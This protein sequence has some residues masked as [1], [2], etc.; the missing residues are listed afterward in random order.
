MI[1]YLKNNEAITI[2]DFPEKLNSITIDN[3]RGNLLIRNS[4]NEVLLKIPRNDNKTN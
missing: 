1:I 2:T 4:K 3:D